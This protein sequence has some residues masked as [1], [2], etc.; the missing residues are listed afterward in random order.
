MLI[1]GH[2]ADFLGKAQEYAFNTRSGDTSLTLNLKDD[3][4]GP[5]I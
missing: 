1:L 4:L 3:T 2:I 5:G